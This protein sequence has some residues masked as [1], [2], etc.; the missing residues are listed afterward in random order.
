VIMTYS[1]LISSDAAPHPLDDARVES[2]VAHALTLDA[3]AESAEVSVVFTD[4]AEVHELNREYRG[5]DRPTDVLS[6]GLSEM[7]QPAGDEPDDG[8]FVL[9]P[10]SGRQLG[11]VIVSVETAARQ[12]AEHGRAPEHELAHLVVHGVLHLLGHDHAEPEE[13][14]R[15]R[16]REDAVL[17]AGGFP[18]GA[19]G[20]NHVHGE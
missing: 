13:E 8:S 11:E 5:V 16:A 3:V 4:D 19:A 12:A 7:A 1:I 17:I 10:G 18:P 14:A 2:L 6:F 15:M 9:P 20:W